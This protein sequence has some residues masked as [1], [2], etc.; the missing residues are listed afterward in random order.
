[1]QF[2]VIPL[3]MSLSELQDLATR[4]QQQI[5]AQQQLLAFKVQHTKRSAACI[6]LL[7]IVLPKEPVVL[8]PSFS[9]TLNLTHY[10]HWK[11]ADL[12][13]EGLYVTHQ[14][15]GLSDGE[16]IQYIVHAEYFVFRLFTHVVLM[17]KQ[18]SASLLL[19][20]AGECVLYYQGNVL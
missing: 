19:L 15:L 11:L 20:L 2:S 12:I 8:Q 14:C 4:Q 9:L 7:L 1:M 3:D 13:S 17:G 6:R 16:H 5:D 10:I 18:L